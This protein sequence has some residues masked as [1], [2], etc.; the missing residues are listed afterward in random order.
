MV[1]V[2]IVAV[3][4]GLITPQLMNATKQAT[5]TACQGNVKTIT[6]ALAEYDLL[7]QGLP[8]GNATAQLHA[9]VSDG[10]LSNDALMGN[11]TMNDTDPD[12]IQIGCPSEVLANAT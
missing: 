12:N 5:L 10:L 7:H 4:I 1:A 9:L 3:M 11:Y 2:V 8:T 6:A